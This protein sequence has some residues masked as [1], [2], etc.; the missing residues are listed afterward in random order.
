M[1]ERRSQLE[2]LLEQSRALARGGRG[3]DAADAGARRWTRTVCRAQGRFARGAVTESRSDSATRLRNPEAAEDQVQRRRGDVHSR[4][5]SAVRNSLL[6]KD[7]GGPWRRGLPGS[8]TIR[9]RSTHTME[10]LADREAIVAAVKA[11]VDA[12]H[13]ISAK[14]RADLQFRQR[15]PSGSGRRCASESMLCLRVA[16]D[17]E[18][19]IAAVEAQSKAIESVHA[20]ANLVA[21]MLEDVRVQ[22]GC[23]RRTE[24]RRRP[25]RRQ[26]RASRVRDCRRRRTLCEHCSTSVSLRSV[27]SRTSPN[28]V[29]GRRTQVPDDEGSRGSWPRGGALTP[30]L[31]RVSSPRERTPTTTSLAERPNALV[32]AGSVG[33]SQGALGENGQALTRLNRVAPQV[34]PL[35]ERCDGRAIQLRDREQRLA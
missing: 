5:S 11:E 18:D 4:S 27:S 34:V 21:N 16:D 35:L 14:S 20:K 25:R 31:A 1:T 17:A 12:I 9:W 29:A 28:C 33:R 2:A 23:A 26:A 32:A 13:Q 19:K 7:A 6:R 24:G 8:A 15:A 30:E 3:E 10:T 22:H